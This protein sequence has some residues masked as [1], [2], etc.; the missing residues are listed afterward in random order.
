MDGYSYYFNN[1]NTLPFYI[2]IGFESDNSLQIKAIVS[3]DINSYVDGEFDVH[4]TYNIQ[5]LKSDQPKPLEPTKIL[6]NNISQIDMFGSDSTNWT[7]GET[8]E[9]NANNISK[10]CGD[11]KVYIV[12]YL[13]I[14]QR[15][16]SKEYTTPPL[17]IFTNMISLPTPTLYRNINRCDI[18]SYGFR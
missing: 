17:R 10:E 3:P 13:T 16:Y 6:A 2:S 12:Y 7:S 9:Y 11:Y 1:N 5:I 14:T 8:F 15:L 18:S 4:F